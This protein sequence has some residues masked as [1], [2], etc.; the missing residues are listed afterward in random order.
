MCTHRCPDQGVELGC[1]IG[2]H[3]AGRQ[4]TQDQQHEQVQG[5]EGDDNQL[6]LS[7]HISTDESISSETISLPRAISRT[8]ALMRIRKKRGIIPDGLVQMRLETF[9]KSFPNLESKFDT[10]ESSTNER[11]AAYQRNIASANSSGGSGTKRK[12]QGE[13]N[14]GG[15]EE[16]NNS[17]GACNSNFKSYI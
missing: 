6:L 11:G 9:R 2:L 7:E 3:T 17:V 15:G 8:A 16:I 4:D 14:M 5:E 1:V 12:R 13:S 10:G